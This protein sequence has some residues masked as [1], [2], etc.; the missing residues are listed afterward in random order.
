MNRFGDRRV[1]YNNFAE[2]LLN[3][4]N[5]NMTYPGLPNT[6]SDADWE[7][8]M[9]MIAGFGFNVFEFWLV[10]R[11]F[12]REGLSNAYGDEFVRQIRVAA[13]AA[14]ACGVKIRAGVGLV[15]T[16]SDW[17]SL[18]PNDPVDWAEARYLWDAWSRRLDCVDIWAIAPGDPGACS[19]NGCTAVTFIDK[20]LEIARLIKGNH[21]GAEI[22]LGTWG[23]PFFGWGI[24]EGPEGWRGE[25]VQKYQHTAWT[26]D[27]ERTRECMEHLIARLDDFPKPFRVMVNMGFNPDGIPEGEMDGRPWVR[28]IAAKVPVESWDFSLTEGEN[29]ILPH[30]RFQRLY[31]QRRR[32]REA[33]GYSGG[34][35]FTMSP[36]LN[37]LSL[38][39]AAR[40]FVEPD[41]DYDRGA[42][43]F[44]ER[45]WGEGAGEIVEDLVLFEIIKEW[46]NHVELD[47]GKE[48]FH[49]RMGRLH[50]RVAAWEGRAA[51]DLAIWP[52]AEYHRGEL[53]FFSRWMR[54]LSGPAPDFA[55]L[56]QEYWN[57]V[58]AIYDELPRHVDPRPENA[59][60]RIVGFFR[61]WR[62]AD[63]PVSGKWA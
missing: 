42:R 53:E 31:E 36:L 7:G 28:R 8:V 30:Y 9:R 54:D 56:R 20:S 60:D 6:W 25:F 4:Y 17:M 51:G 41:A 21:P 13:R 23:P 33:G 62:N 44:Y 45:I 52:S 32:E 3:R 63:G 59:T 57:R 5:P 58:Y 43:E 12:C 2:H 61:Q 1:Y 40:S 34:I 50:D 19:R 24:I 26:F 15:T 22:M 18:C 10:P 48:E 14:R 47:I 46:G 35:C 39:Q 16:G 55:S 37:Q 29:A 49:R 27:A 11:R 38:Y